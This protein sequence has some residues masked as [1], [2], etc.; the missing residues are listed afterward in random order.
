MAFFPI[1]NLLF[2]NEGKDAQ[3]NS[4]NFNFTTEWHLVFTYAAGQTFSF[5]GDDD[6]WVFIDGQLQL[7]IG[8]IHGG[9]PGTINLDSLGFAPGSDH[10]FDIYYC[11]RHVVA[12]EIEIQTSIK[13]TGSV[14]VVVN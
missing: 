1:D 13:F 14:P 9:L 12:S 4:H 7:D 11:E 8:G 2:G 3:G 10:G 5:R 6:L